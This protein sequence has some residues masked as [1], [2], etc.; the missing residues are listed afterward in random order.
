MR[1]NR[2]KF[3]PVYD[4]ISA[5]HKR[6]LPKSHQNS[7]PGLKRALADIAGP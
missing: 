7:S 6:I 2:E 4:L 5:N 1:L 3:V